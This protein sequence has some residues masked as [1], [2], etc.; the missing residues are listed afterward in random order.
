MA[1]YSLYKTNIFNLFIWVTNIYQ[2]LSCT[3]HCAGIK[4]TVAQIPHLTSYNFR[5][6]HSHTHRLAIIIWCCESYV[7]GN[8]KKQAPYKEGSLEKMKTAVGIREGGLRQKE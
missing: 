5:F 4:G 1:T 7:R 3:R 6:R 8:S 2:V